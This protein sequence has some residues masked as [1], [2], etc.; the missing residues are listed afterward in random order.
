M[1]TA[2]TGLIIIMV[3]LLAVL[4]LSYSFL[5]VQ[6]AVVES[7]Q[8]MEERMEDRVRTDLSPVGAETSIGGSY[9]DVTLGNEGDTK[10]A[11]FDQWD[12]IVQY[13][14]TDGR[15]HIEWLPYDGSGNKWT[16][17]GIYLDASTSTPE[18]FDIDI[19]NPGEEIVIQMWLSPTVK[20]SSTNLAT[21]AVPNG[22]TVSTVFTR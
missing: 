21:V 14:G 4:I 13:D 1:D 7:W 9:V 12:V 10:L 11:D 16:K 20:L 6:Q 15:N 17:V 5:S 19:L 2:L 18:V 3:L 8:E 22:I